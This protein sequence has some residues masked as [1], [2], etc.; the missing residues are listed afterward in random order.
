MRNAFC[1]A[2]AKTIHLIIRSFLLPLSTAL[3]LTSQAAPP[4]GSFLPNSCLSPLLLAPETYPPAPCPPPDN[5]QLF[6]G[7]GI[8]TYAPR[9]FRSADHSAQ[10]PPAMLLHGRIGSAALRGCRPRA[11]LGL[12]G[13]GGRGGWLR[14][15]MP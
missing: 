6:P 10:S 5:K 1:E 3:S 11:G 7:I 8:A 15:R 14:T 4:T 2:W 13:V 9:P 12:R